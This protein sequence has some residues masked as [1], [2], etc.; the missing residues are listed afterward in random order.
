MKHFYQAFCSTIMTFQ[1]LVVLLSLCNCFFS[2]SSIFHYRKM[3]LYTVNTC[4]Y[5]RYVVTFYTLFILDLLIGRPY[6]N[7]IQP[8]VFHIKLVRDATV[9]TISILELADNLPKEQ[10]KTVFV[11]ALLAMI[12]Y[13]HH[14]L[15]EYYNGKNDTQNVELN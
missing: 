11:I 12:L 9:F 7:Y 3:G 1:P 13:L 2:R 8:V 5:T 4:R 14:R 10:Q 6:I 15:D